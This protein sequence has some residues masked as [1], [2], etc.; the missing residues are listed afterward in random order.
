VGVFGFGIGG[1]SGSVTVGNGRSRELR[2]GRCGPEGG[3]MA[4]RSAIR[5]AVGGDTECGRDELEK[6]RHPRPF[7]ITQ[8]S[9]FL[10]ALSSLIIALD[11]PTASFVR[12][13][14]RRSKPNILGQSGK[15]NT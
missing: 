12:G 9:Q 6:P 5:E 4:P 3:G 7:I 14:T 13:S 10:P 11:A 1:A 2:G 8:G 15:P